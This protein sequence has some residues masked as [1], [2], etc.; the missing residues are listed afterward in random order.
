M[1]ETETT[2]T[3]AEDFKDFF[4]KKFSVSMKELVTFLLEQVS[5]ENS[6]HS[7]LMKINNILNNKNI[8]YKR[9]V[10]KLCNNEKIIMNLTILKESNINETVLDELLRKGSAKDWVLIPEF[11]VDKIIREI[12]DKQV[13]NKI[14]DDIKDIF[15]CAESYN[16]IDKMISDHDYEETD[17]QFDP[18]KNLTASNNLSDINVNTMFKDVKYKQMTSYEMLIKMMV[19]EKTEN[20]VGEYMN[21]IKEDDVNDAASKLDDVLKST[22]SNGNA[23]KLLGTMLSNIKDEV[24]EMGGQQNS[25]VEGKEAMEK[26]MG[27]AKKVAGSMAMDVQSSGLTPMEIWEATSALARK[28][29]KSDALDIV[30]GI[31]KQNIYNGMNNDQ[32]QQTGIGDDLQNKLK[33]LNFDDEN[34]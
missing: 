20:K 15:V 12:K 23:S 24:I 9:L 7:K 3:T 32:S 10:N 33:M 19:D 27:I 31:I 17:G 2:L 30:D 25:K 28:T 1:S 13:I 34:D 26:L 21:N 16:G 29:V 22:E 6:T 14:I 8:D 18:V 11:H 4:L 5:E